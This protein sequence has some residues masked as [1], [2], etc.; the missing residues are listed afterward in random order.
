MKKITIFILVLMLQ[1][2]YCNAV[3]QFS[4]EGKGTKDRP[5]EIRTAKQLEEV[6]KFTDREDVYFKL[7]KDICLDNSYDYMTGSYSTVGIGSSTSPFRGFF[8]GGGHTI[9]NVKRKGYGIHQVI[10]MEPDTIGHV[11]VGGVFNYIK[12]ATIRNLK[13]KDVTVRG[14]ESVGGLVGR[15][16]ESKIE[17]CEIYDAT[18]RGDN[19]VGGLVGMS[20]DTDIVDSYACTAVNGRDAVGGLVGAVAVYRDGIL[21]I[22]RC[23]TMGTVD[24]EVSGGGI[25]GRGYLNGTVVQN[26]CGLVISACNSNSAVTCDEYAGGVAGILWGSNRAEIYMDGVTVHGSYI[27]GAK[28]AGIATCV[29]DLSDGS[30]V[31]KISV[32]NCLVASRSLEGSTYTAGLVY[33]EFNTNK[34]IDFSGYDCFVLS[35]CVVASDKIMAD[36]DVYEGANLSAKNILVR[37]DVQMIGNVKAVSGSEIQKIPTDRLMKS[38]AYESIGWKFDEWAIVDNETFPYLGW[39]SVPVI[40][41]SNLETGDANIEGKSFE[42]TQVNVD[43]LGR[44]FSAMSSDNAW[45]VELDPMEI[46]DGYVSVHARSADNGPSSVTPVYV[47]SRDD[48]TIIFE[49]PV[50]VYNYDDGIEDDVRSR[51]FLVPRFSTVPEWIKVYVKLQSSNRGVYNFGSYMRVDGEKFYSGSVGETMIT[52]S[53]G[54]VSATC[55]MI[56]TGK[57]AIDGVNTDSDYMIAINGKVLS[58]SSENAI[59]VDLYSISGVLLRQCVCRAGTTEMELVSGTYILRIGT[60]VHKIYIR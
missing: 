56:I 26:R 36:N 45:V 43:C 14:G 42:A 3:V 24:A 35:S 8:D 51:F 38:Q 16:V 44:R 20:Y 50:V 5:Y 28:T 21:Y 58:V 12:G 4:G 41:D 33:L 29:D 57:N 53:W 48:V 47:A 39:Q 22:R 10:D 15:A 17:N 31:R 23:W 1:F 18:V 19:Y 49:E 46:W 59:R 32:R 37:D 60:N 55:K 54:K 34:P 6:H 27:R 40:V 9:S 7:V 11:N 25:I 52:A 2:L 30:P 13:L